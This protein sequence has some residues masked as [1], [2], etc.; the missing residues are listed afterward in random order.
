MNAQVEVKLTDELGNLVAFEMGGEMMA[1]PTAILREV[2]EP[3]KI[4]RVPTAGPF[5]VGLMNVRGAVIPVSDLRP[6]FSMPRKE[7]DDETRIIVLDLDMG[8]DTMSVGIIVERVHAVFA[9]DDTTLQSVPNVGTRWPH[10]S[11]KAIGRWDG[12]F[13]NLPDI[14]MIF[15]THLAEAKPA[16]GGND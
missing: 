9:L 4:T 3:P 12:R 7:F 5:A 1:V 14:A 15:E 2:L 16:G 6:Y 11:V 10:R 13:V 8:D